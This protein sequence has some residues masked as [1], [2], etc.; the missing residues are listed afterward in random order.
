[1]GLLV[2]IGLALPVASMAAAPGTVIDNVAYANYTVG[3][4]NAVSV[5]SNVYS[6]TTVGN[7]TPSTLSVYQYA[8]APY[9]TLVLNVPASEYSTG[10]AS[11][12]FTNSPA[13]TELDGTP[14]NL[15]GVSLRPAT[16]I[17]MGE[18]IFFVLEDLDQNVNPLAPDTVIITVT[19]PATGETEIIR[20]TETGNSTGVFAGYVQTAKA[21]ALSMSGQL[22]LS[23]DTSISVAYVDDADSTDMASFTAPVDPSALAF[24]SITGAPLDGVSVSIVNASTGLPAT[25]YGDDG[26]SVFPSTVTT[27][28]T[29]TDASSA[30][31]S[32]STG[33][34]RFPYIPAGSYRYVVTPPT[35]YSM[36]STR[37]DAEIQSIPGAPFSL[38]TGSRGEDFSIGAEHLVEIDIPL[39]PAAGR[40]YVRKTASKDSVAIGDFLQYEITV[41]ETAGYP[42][43]G[44]WAADLL[45]LGFKYQEGSAKI[46]GAAVADPSISGDGRTLTF[47]LGDLGGDST[48]TIKLVVEVAA[49]AS[50]GEAINF[51]YAGGDNGASSNMA[52]VTVQVKD[53]FFA[54]KNFLVGRVIADGCSLAPGAAGE[55]VANVRIYMEDGTYVITDE[56]GRFHFQ[57]ISADT[58]VV[59][60]DV[61]SLPER[62][63]PSL[64]EDNTAFAGRAYS[65]FVSLKTGALWRVDF[66]LATKPAPS[67]HLRAELKSDLVANTVTYRL[68]ISVGAIDV[69]NVRVMA[70]MPDGAQY[71]KGSARFGLSSAT[72]ADFGGAIQFS[73]GNMRAGESGTLEFRVNLDELKGVG[74][75]V[76]KVMVTFDTPSEKGVRTPSLDNVLVR[77]SVEEGGGIGKFMVRTSFDPSSAELNQDHKA[78]LDRVIEEIK[79]KKIKHVFAFGYSDTTPISVELRGTYKNNYE[80]SQARARS[81]V[82]YIGDYLGLPPHKLSFVGFGEDDPVA[83]NLTDAGKTLNRRVEVKIYFDDTVTRTVLRNE[84]PDSGA[85]IVNTT[86]LDPWAKSDASAAAEPEDQDAMPVFDRAWV[87]SAGPGL[88][89]IWPPSGYSPS[90]PATHMAVKHDPA[91]KLMLF[92]NGSEVPNVYYERS[93]ANAS[94][95]VAVTAWRGV[96]IGDGTNVIEA[97]EF[98][99]DGKEL[100]SAKYEISYVTEPENVELITAMSRLV[101]DGRTTPVIAIKLTD[102]EGRPVRRG[103]M[104]EFTVKSPYTA[105][106]RDNSITGGLDEGTTKYTVGS[107]GIA[108]I[109]LQPTVQTGQASLDITLKSG[110]K[111]VTAWLDPSMRDWIL[112]GLAEGTAGYNSVSGNMESL[113]SMQMDD[114]LYEDGKLMFFAKGR[115]KGEWLLTM[116]YDS[117]KASYDEKNLFSIIDPDEYYTLYGDS[118]E[119]AYEAASSRKLYLK[120]ERR[121][122][123]AL[124][125][126]F[127]TGLSVTELST[128]DRSM[129]GVKAEYKGDKVEAIVFASQTSHAYIRDE[130][131]ADGTSGLYTMT[132]GNIVTNSEKVTIET[133]E[134]NSKIEVLETRHLSR[135]T[136]YDIDYEDGTLYFK[137]PIN[138]TDDDFN[139][140]Y[141][142]IEYESYN[143]S[144]E[145]LN[146]GARGAVNVAEGKAKVGATVVHE[147]SVGL[148]GDLMGADATVKLTEKDTLRAEVAKTETLDQG[149][150]SSGSAYIVEVAHEEK[151]LSG[152]AYVKSYGEGFGLGQQS[153]SSTATRKSGADMSYKI[154][155]RW[156]TSATAYRQTD[157]EEQTDDD[158]MELGAKYKAERYSLSA[159]L[160]HAVG[161]GDEDE[162]EVSDQLTTGASWWTKD[163]KL[164]LGLK[165]EQALFGQNDNPDYPT[166]TGLDASYRLTDSLR[167]KAG[168]EITE[169]GDVRYNASNVGL[170]AKPWKGGELDSTIDREFDEDG[171]RVYS[172][173]GLSQKFELNKQWIVSSSLD[174]K[175]TLR[176]VLEADSDSETNNDYSAV[177]LGANYDV[178]DFSWHNRLEFRDTDTQDKLGMIVGATGEPQEGTGLSLG[179]EAFDD[180]NDG[181]QETEVDIRFGFVHRPLAARW[182]VLDRLDLIYDKQMAEDSD[183]STWKVVNNLNAN[184]KPSGKYQVS[185]KY[186]AK[187][188]KDVIDEDD[189]KGFTDL[190]GLESRHYIDRK[191]DVGPRMSMLHSWHAGQKKYMYGLSV[192]Y[193]V[194]TNMWLNIGYNVDGFKDA[195]FSEADF[196]AKGPFMRFSIKFDQST[197]R[198]VVKWYTGL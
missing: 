74:S 91:N 89:V 146:Y 68:P 120:I 163:G 26:V 175:Q 139:P 126:D 24:D 130:I 129:N 185:I 168:H 95:T 141:I 176:S 47:S 165:R 99:P 34:F 158:L 66:H 30:S 80:L 6:I 161:E 102:G 170:S 54:S 116:A 114:G 98:G 70:V 157:L 137:E 64:C 60:L 164:V 96:H 83:A 135:H 127:E 150:A 40:L 11:G 77:E 73:L 56:K 67:G 78:E 71:E 15:A 32:F 79:G 31:Y 198:E 160:R 88:D 85:A 182:I 171:M 72:E 92:V 103:L 62:Y 100:R 33:G 7:R 143:D 1:M 106:Q 145:K 189:Y 25:V 16:I 19:D 109:E 117:T 65:Q 17:H 194:D 113:A 90:K 3:A 51:A 124:F 37:T 167:L 69:D 122:F 50:E 181:E 153:E 133:R 119:Q 184:F 104:G 179:V 192:G 131:E 132:R 10:N 82:R 159:G 12:P 81:V 144:D 151:N 48:T 18:P 87:E 75:L 195:D 94:G 9:S 191:W 193:S 38:T 197:A 188:V 107:G 105:K 8:E 140:N 23:P 86:G 5:Q 84:R 166:L 173:L 45:P 43:T 152:K 183:I 148:E 22:S 138:V 178:K 28:G 172:N 149:S 121:Q 108:M 63:E 2:L 123:Y 177:S 27:G 147:E 97:V 154:D 186:G 155:E 46:N 162:R 29:F 110:K 44:A 35:G 134:R 42:V 111:Q 196:T 59:Q 53:E 41:E 21:P 14:I 190:I 4:T 174:R 55:G 20:L 58:H 13:P 39:D 125:G 115:I 36:P 112:V 136:D 57:G 187:Y 180:R 142:V 128:Y 169:S 61:D 93:V 49:G 101:A 156:S 118:T 52:S 76:T